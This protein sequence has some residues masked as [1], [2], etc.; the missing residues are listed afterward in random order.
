MQIQK[1]EDRERVIGTAYNHM[2]FIPK[3]GTKLFTLP[4]SYPLFINIEFMRFIN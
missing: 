2:Y 1:N 3:I 4:V